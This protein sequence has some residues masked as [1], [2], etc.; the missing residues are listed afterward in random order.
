M[1]NK[2]LKLK[3]IHVTFL[4]LAMVFTMTFL[5]P[6]VYT[7]ANYYYPTLY[8]HMLAYSVPNNLKIFYF[9]QLVFACLILKERFKALN[10]LIVSRTVQCRKF[11]KISETNQTRECFQ[12]YNNLCNGIDLINSTFTFH[13]IASIAAILVWTKPMTENLSKILISCFLCCFQDICNFRGIC[14]CEGTSEKR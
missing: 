1:N 8:L 2:S 7:V 10:G 3:S 12:I 5:G 13:L 6:I 14:L 9:A 4:T 11:G